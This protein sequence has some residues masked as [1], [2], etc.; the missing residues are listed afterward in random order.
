MLLREAPSSRARTLTF[1]PASIRRRASSLNSRL[2]RLGSL[3]VKPVLLPRKEGCHHFPCFKL[4]VHSRSYRTHGGQP[5]ADRV[6]AGVARV[7]SV[8]IM[9]GESSSEL[10]AHDY[11]SC[12]L[13]STFSRTGRFRQTLVLLFHRSGSRVEQ[14]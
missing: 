8:T 2:N 1:S 3:V 7:F 13:E 6:V 4:G 14:R 11:G 12:N 10:N 5:R 9:G